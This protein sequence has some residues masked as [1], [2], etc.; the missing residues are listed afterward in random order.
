M[1][2]HDSLRL[3]QFRQRLTDTPDLLTR[4]HERLPRPFDTP[5]A[6]EH[7]APVCVAFF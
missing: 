6:N 4:T 3:A 1:T 2:D 7:D 5:G